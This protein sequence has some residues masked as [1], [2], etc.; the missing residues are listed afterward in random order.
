MSGREL[1]EEVQ[2]VCELQCG[3]KHGSRFLPERPGNRLAGSDRIGTRTKTQNS[4]KGQLKV[5]LWQGQTSP[6]VSSPYGK[7]IVPGPLNTG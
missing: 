2:D 6:R 3:G 4:G 5:S 7:N 1:R